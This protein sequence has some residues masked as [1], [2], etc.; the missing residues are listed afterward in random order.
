MLNLLMT[1]ALV[2]ERGRRLL[3][4]AGTAR[5]ARS[6]RIDRTGD[7]SGR[8]PLARVAQRDDGGNPRSPH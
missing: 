6:A 8:R 1:E 7:R 3:D 2:A 5:L 4:D